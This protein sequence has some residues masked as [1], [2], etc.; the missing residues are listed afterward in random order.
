MALEYQSASNGLK[1]ELKEPD[2]EK[3]SYIFRAKDRVPN[4]YLFHFMI[5]YFSNY[6]IFGDFPLTPTL[7]LQS[8]SFF[9]TW[10]IAK[11][12]NGL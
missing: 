6:C 4:F 7:K 11:N 10:P 12:S 3:G 9:K 5:N 1:T 8:A 2:M